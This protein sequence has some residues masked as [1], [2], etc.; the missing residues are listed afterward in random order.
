[1]PP[2]VYFRLT[3]RDQ[4]GNL[5]AAQTPQPVVVDLK[6]PTARLIRVQPVQVQQP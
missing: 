6:K 3:A 2:A 1:M 5:A 4:A